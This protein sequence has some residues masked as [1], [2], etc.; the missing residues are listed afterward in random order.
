[1]SKSTKI[2]A[3][4]GVAAG[5]GIAALPAA[6]FAATSVEVP[7]KVTIDDVLS[8]SGVTTG[9]F[10]STTGI[11]LEAG[12]NDAQ[13]QTVWT[14]TSND[15]DGWTVTVA[16]TT[17]GSNVLTNA[18]NETIDPFAT[19]VT[20]LSENT[21]SGWGIKLNNLA[22]GVSAATSA[23]TTTGF[24][25]V[26]TGPDQVVTSSAPS[27]TAGKNFTTIYGVDLADDQAAGVYAGSITFTIAA[28]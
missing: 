20:D 11:T 7:L 23:F 19:E 28:N 25:G 2:I 4:L 16:P 26:T 9:D 12:Q 5:L 13:S 1:M 24:K 22:D 27:G 6:T 18:T 10:A 21:T 17:N 15:T 14:A 3:A 8:L